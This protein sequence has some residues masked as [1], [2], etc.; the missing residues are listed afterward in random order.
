[1]PPSDRFHKHFSLKS[2]ICPTADSSTR[3]SSRNWNTFTQQQIFSCCNPC[4]RFSRYKINL[5]KRARQLGWYF[6]RRPYFTA[7]LNLL[8]HYPTSKR[9]Q[10][11]SSEQVNV[12]KYCRFAICLLLGIHLA[13]KNIAGTRLRLDTSRSFFN[14]SPLPRFEIVLRH[15]H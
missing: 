1:M 8:N 7:D 4:I 14:G 6:L 11:L 13:V 15:N 9:L 2:T 10:I 12:S 3:L 5:V